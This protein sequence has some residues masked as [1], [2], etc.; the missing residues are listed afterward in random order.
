M[1]HF[2]PIRYAVGGW[3]SVR[4]VCQTVCRCL[5]NTSLLSSLSPWQSLSR[6]WCWTELSLMCYWCMVS[7]LDWRVWV[8]FCTVAKIGCCLP[9]NTY[10]FFNTISIYIFHN[11]NLPPDLS[12]SPPLPQEVRDYLS[13]RHYTLHT[14]PPPYVSVNSVAKHR[15]TLTSHSDTRGGGVAA[16]IGE[17]WEGEEEVSERELWMGKW[18]VSG[19][20][21]GWRGKSELI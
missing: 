15:D 20:L 1:T 21:W 10:W 8:K 18:E 12:D 11:T 19:K 9:P 5:V 6:D 13:T 3:C 17:L 14:L 4:P 16:R 7:R 2:S